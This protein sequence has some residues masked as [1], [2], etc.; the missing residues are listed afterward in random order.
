MYAQLCDQW[1][2]IRQ[3]SIVANVVNKT[4]AFDIETDLSESPQDFFTRDLD[5]AVLA[6]RL[7]LAVH[8]AK[9]LPEPIVEGLDWFWLPWRADPRDVV[10][11]RKGCE[12]SDL[13]VD[14]VIGVS[15]DRREA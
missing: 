15:S 7:D 4:R 9:D 12:I 10:V 13:P 6:G 2:Y 14:P 3:G 1:E 11:V 5:E 8:S